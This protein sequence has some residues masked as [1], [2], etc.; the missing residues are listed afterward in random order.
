MTRTI[1]PKEI[2]RD[3]IFAIEAARAAG[4]RV[5]ALREKGRWEGAMLADVGDQ[6]ADGFLQGFVRGRYPDDGIL[7]EE[8]ADSE[9]RLAKT[10]AWIIDPLDGTREFSEGR[11]DWG[12]HVALTI[13]G[14]CALGAVALPSDDEVLWGVAL[15]GHERAGSVNG[16]ELLRGDSAR[17]G[18]LKVVVSRSHTPPW[19]EAFAK[20]L[21]AELL[22]CGGAG[23]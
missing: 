4:R 20:R 12:V 22:P 19:V 9:E 17:E 23:Y 16:A 7:S 15:E 5:L 2:E 3:L 21:G 14:Q 6:A 13:A 18:P 8:T 1:T 11:S 10:R